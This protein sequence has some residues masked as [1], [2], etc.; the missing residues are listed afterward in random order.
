MTGETIKFGRGRP[1]FD[2]GT[3]DAEAGSSTPV[4][5]SVPYIR[6]PRVGAPLARVPKGKYIIPLLHIPKV[7][8][9]D[10][11]LV[12]RLYELGFSNHDFLDD[13]KFPDF[14]PQY[15][16]NSSVVVPNQPL[17]LQFQQWALGL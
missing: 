17:V 7:V 1:Q 12:G 9:L 15:Y 14:K 5:R 2:E 3:H 16:M 13:N 4:D 10:G 8:T 6:P 11:S